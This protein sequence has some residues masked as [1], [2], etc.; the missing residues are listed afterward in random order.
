MCILLQDVKILRHQHHVLHFLCDK[1]KRET[2]GGKE[3]ISLPP[4]CA[5]KQ[6]KTKREKW[7]RRGENEKKKQDSKM[8]TGTREKL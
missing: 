2:E 8:R 6:R 4:L 5:S 3:K 1:K 7:Q